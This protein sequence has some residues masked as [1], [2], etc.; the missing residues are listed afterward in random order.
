MKERV[1]PAAILAIGIA[2]AA[3][4]FGGRYSMVRDG[5]NIVWRLDRYTGDVWACG[6]PDEQE[7]AGCGKLSEGGE[8]AIEPASEN[9]S[10]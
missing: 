10:R 7:M 2:L 9:L 6:V 3:F 4:L 8:L 5:S 1:L